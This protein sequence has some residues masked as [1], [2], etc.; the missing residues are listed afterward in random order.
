MIT[1]G[2]FEPLEVEGDEGRSSQSRG[3]AK[4]A[5]FGI[6]IVASLR[7]PADHSFSK[8]HFD[9]RKVRRHSDFRRCLGQ[10]ISVV[11]CFH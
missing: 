1:V 8:P 5:V 2:N 10:G 6:G 11:V 3:D 7:N 4:A 9:N